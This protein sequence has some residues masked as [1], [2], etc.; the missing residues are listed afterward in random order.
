[1][2]IGRVGINNNACVFFVEIGGS[3]FGGVHAEGS[4]GNLVPG[5]FT[6]F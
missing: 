4:T 5:D 2:G 1:M 3:A 6:I